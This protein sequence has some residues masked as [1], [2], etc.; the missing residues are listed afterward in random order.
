MILADF[1]PGTLTSFFVLM[2]FALIVVVFLVSAGVAL[3]LGKPRSIRLYLITAGAAF[4]IGVL[5]YF[6]S[7]LW[8][9]HFT[10]RD[11]SNCA[12]S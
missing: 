11:A 5:S 9:G 2:A 10:S 12:G 8:L 6:L 1:D 3:A 4:G 7:F